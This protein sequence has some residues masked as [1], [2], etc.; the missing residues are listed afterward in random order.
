MSDIPQSV[1]LSRAHPD[2][3]PKHIAKAL[4]MPLEQVLA[5]LRMHGAL[6]EGSES[7]SDE[8][9]AIIHQ[10]AK[11]GQ[12]EQTRLKAATILLDETLGRRST[13]NAGTRDTVEALNAAIKSA[14]A[15][16]KSQY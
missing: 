2:V 13:K 5:E 3:E 6:R 4:N 15:D 12:S 9:L 10:I 1:Q 11:G 14:V 16:A 7:V 8:A